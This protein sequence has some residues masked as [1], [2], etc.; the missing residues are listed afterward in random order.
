MAALFA[1]Q[2]FGTHRVG[3]LF[4]P[5]LLAWLVCISGV[6][7]YN[8]ARWNPHI[9]SALSP[10]YIY[11]FFKKSGSDGWA[12]LAGVF[13]SITGLYQP[14]ITSFALDFYLMTLFEIFPF[15][16]KGAEAMFA[17]LGHFSKISIRVSFLV[18]WQS[19]ISWQAGTIC[20][21]YRLCSSDVLCSLG[22]LMED[23]VI[24]TL[25]VQ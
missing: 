21:R 6:G 17:D 11:N 4:A 12:S 9:V 10:H 23:T 14:P 25:L 18:N 19:Q 8:I 2:H 24:I 22:D 16:H 1:L 5:I 13:L 15:C 7:V 3:F 20:I